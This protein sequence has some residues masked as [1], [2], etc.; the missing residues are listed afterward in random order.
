MEI[1]DYIPQ[2]PPEVFEGFDGFAPG[3]DVDAFVRSTLLNEA[4]GLFNID[5][6]HLING[7]I[8]YLWTAAE[9][10]RRGRRVVGEAETPNF[11]VGAWQKGRQLFQIRNWFGDVPDFIVTL[12][13]N[14]WLEIS[15]VERLAIVEHELYHCGQAL[16]EFGFPRFSKETGNPIF[17]L[18]GHDIEE[19]AGVVRRYGIEATGQNNADFV[20]AAGRE[21]EIS[22]VRL[23]ELCGT[24]K[25]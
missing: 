11:R 12:D 20:A 4:H 15:D 5:H 25:V 3:P 16:D 17:A 1:T 19:F 18:R 6:A 23:G 2:P 22:R 24:C 13:A 8:G 9:N 14:Y 10:K 21:P 7:F